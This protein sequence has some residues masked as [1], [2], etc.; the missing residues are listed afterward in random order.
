MTMAT[1]RVAVCVVT[2]QR[3]DCLAELLSALAQL[4]FSRTSPDVRVVVVDN[5]AE[6]SAA[7]TVANARATMPFPMSYCV[8]QT[9]G[10]SQAR[11][12]AL[13]IAALDVDFIAFIDDDEIPAVCWLDELLVAQQAY[14]AALVAGPVIARLPYGAPAWAS[15]GRFFERQRSRTGT[16][17]RCAGAGNLLIATAALCRI[18]DF[19][20]SLGAAGG[21]DADFTM[22]AS[23]AG[24]QIVWCDEAVVAE[25]VLPTR[26]NAKWLCLRWFRV[27]RTFHQLELAQGR[28]RTSL[29]LTMLAKTAWRSGQGIMW[30][31]LSPVG[32]FHCI[33]S[34]LRSMATAAGTIA[35]ILEAMTRGHTRLSPGNA[36]SAAA[37]PL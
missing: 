14:A 3:L 10:Y 13:S 32:G 28:T 27:A 37:H 29:L 36:R 15:K 16:V 30:L 7:S 31:A 11:N 18:G 6:G 19:N 2:R 9:P 5:D 26:V 23:Q 35:A 21:E 22:R 25:T 24:C 17:V 1:P 34:G 4:R 8:E 12:C 33:I 20:P